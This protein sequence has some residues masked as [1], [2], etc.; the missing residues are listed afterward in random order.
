MSTSI[1]VY[2]I[3]HLIY[4]CPTTD[5]ET[6]RVDPDDDTPLSEEETGPGETVNNADPNQNLIPQPVQ[7]M[8]NDELHQ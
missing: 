4:I 8:N 6:G 1:I 7:Y 2:T 3:K 5:E